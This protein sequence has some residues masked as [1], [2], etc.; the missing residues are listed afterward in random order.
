MTGIR[1]LTHQ[2]I[3]P[4]IHLSNLPSDPSAAV[5][6]PAVAPNTPQALAVR[7]APST[8]T[9]ALNNKAN[10]QTLS[11]NLYAL[12]KQ[13]GPDA[14]PQAVR[15]ALQ[16]TSMAL[17]H[18]LSAS[19]AQGATATL[20]AF[21]T[22]NNLGLPTT[23]FHLTALASALSQRALQ[24]PLENLAGALGWP[25]PLSSDQQRQLRSITQRHAHHLGDQRLVMQTKGV[26]AFL[27]YQ[28]PLSA[29]ELADPVKT[30]NALLGAPEARHLGQALQTRMGGIASDSSVDDYLLAAIA[31][32]MDHE[33]I[34]A[35][36]RHKVAG[37]DLAQQAHWGKPAATVVE[38]L[39]QHLQ[40]TG[41][42]SALLAKAA[43]HVLL[44]RKAPEYLIKDIPANVTYGS[45]AWVSLSIAAAVIE[46]GAPGSVPGMS[47]ADVMS[48]A[49]AASMNHPAVAEQAQK[50]ALVDWAV[51]NGM[52]AK[53][54][55]DQ[56]P[57]QTLNAL[58]TAFNQ[59][60]SGL[61]EASQGL[62]QEMPARREIALAKLIAR[63]GD[64][65]D[66][67][68]EKL[69]TT[70]DYAGPGRRTSLVGRHSLLDIA[71]MDLPSPAP[72]ESR[73]T[74][75]PLAALNANPRFGVT[76]AFDLAFEAATSEKKSAV[77]TTVKHLI[78][79]LPVEDRKN[80]EF[81]KVTFYQQ[82]SFTLG[83]DFTS[84][85]SGP[86]SP[87]LWVKTER[88]GVTTAYE[89]NLN[90]G[91]IAPAP[92]YL[93]Q[94]QR[95]RDGSKVEQTKVFLP[96]GSATRLSSERPAG[97]KTWDSFN[98]T[99]SSDIADVF[100]N[101]LDFDNPAI[102][103]H[104]LGKTTLDLQTDRAKPVE[105]FILNL[106]PFR[107]AIVNF[108]NGQYGEGATD[109]ALDIF[110]FL[111]AGLATAGK[112]AKISATAASA[113]TKALRAAKVIGTTTM[114]TFNPLG[115]LGD[116]TVGGVSFLGAKGAQVFNRVRGASGSYDVLKAVSK[117]FDAAAIGTLKI[118]GQ[119]VDGAAVLKNGHWYG[120]DAD[121]M[122]PFG[123]PLDD[124]AAVTQAVDGSVGTLSHEF[125]HQ[126]F[127]Q[128][129]V[130]ETRIAGL[131]RNS[132]GVYVAVD[133]HQSFI[134]HTDSTGQTAV[135]EVRQVTRTQDG[136]VQAR[137]YH[138][139]RQT[140]L[141]I[142][143]VEGD[144]WQRLGA[145][146]GVLIEAEHLRA[147]EALSPQEQ[148]RLTVQGFAKQ[149][150]LNAPT[151]AHYVQPNGQLSASG[152]TVR[153][154][155]PGTPMN[156][157]T[158]DH[159]R[160]W[161]GMTQQARNAMTMEG[162]AGLHHLKVDAFKNSVRQDGSLGAFGE[163]VLF[164]AGGG[165]YSPLSD[166]HLLRWSVLVSQPGNKV[167]PEIF[168]RQN[169]INPMDWQRYVSVDGSFNSVGANR[170][171]RAQ[172][173]VASTS[174]ASTSRKRPAPDSS[175]PPQQ[176][177]VDLSKPPTGAQ[178][179][180]FPGPSSAKRPVIKVEPDT[181]PLRT[182]PAHQI[183]NSLP[184]LQDP[185]NPRLSLT[186][187]I[188]GPIDDIRIAN[189]HG[190]LD[191]LEPAQRTEVAARIKDS[192]KDWLRT[193][194]Q[195]GSRFE[196]TLELATA[197][198]DGG[199]A[200]GVSVWARRDIPQFEVLGPYTGKYH[201]SVAS[202]FQ[203]QR[204]QGARAVLTYLFN[205]RSKTRTVS[206][207][208]SSNILSL[209]NTS[210]LRNGPV[211]RANNVAIVSVGKNLTFY[212]ALKDIKKADEL[213]VD[214]GPFY[215]TVPDIAIKPDPGP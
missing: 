130:P 76:Q 37:F 182:L 150:R 171:S 87:G 112:V 118:A 98:S 28:N 49:K 209:V 43:A 186:Q 75:I 89:I 142:Q 162:F 172:Q 30:L 14:S 105:A 156:P 175:N 119:A 81:G 196:Q 17:R 5:A 212:V 180:Q 215:Q 194:G 192:I 59:R 157:L 9:A 176:V 210:Q 86:T 139:N 131:S 147:W 211:W 205:T 45:P 199:P 121:N 58:G 115:G 106:I 20:E 117:Q 158:A 47:F 170:L 110:G 169:R 11:E 103:Q 159:V 166:E 82:T 36:H 173:N 108:Q 167:T 52:L 96:K 145:P 140:E 13:L 32:Q 55:D 24:H 95:D 111:T 16:S 189:W 2:R 74:R 197:L 62:D 137:V 99:R 34:D 93:V 40:S 94:E 185:Q 190:L 179:V 64:L 104:A 184:I 18:D 38:G 6:S 65:G 60:V 8:L 21:I 178:S 48:Q 126:L 102:K 33:S 80:L 63:F 51:A 152:V 46:A 23:H 71:M 207:F 7:Q 91:T 107:S 188:E 41:K 90:K 67:F 83:L 3:T 129:N 135:Y 214:Y 133:G 120:F 149:R 29:A 116:L 57:A 148:Q 174:S 19:S 88:D 39:A 69:I 27:A 181:P 204:K 165:T 128:F 123:S 168:Q 113:A 141:L 54:G 134:R 22:S 101:H 206:A 132:Q 35:P 97:E 61:L 138:N 42:T 77:A 56:Y 1:S 208:N 187:T 68:E 151:F 72:F 144:H 143:H 153:D 122:R 25:I 73:D 127:A 163:S 15:S 53:R 200:R 100:V 146:G 193:E 10:L 79:Q 161:Q 44:A 124:F 203:E 114:A 50:A 198:D 125:S 202:L 191:G 155:A 160:D 26:L 136:V 85:T 109:L 31:V 4:N 164:K 177:P 92:D 84:T 154:R 70:H 12:A 78:S 66:L 201:E 213:L 183:D 195:H